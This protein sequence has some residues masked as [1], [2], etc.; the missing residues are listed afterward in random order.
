[1]TSQKTRTISR[2]AMAVTAICS[3]SAH[4][5]NVVILDN[6]STGKLSAVVTN[7]NTGL[8]CTKDQALYQKLCNSFKSN[9]LKVMQKNADG[10]LRV[11][12]GVGNASSTSYQKAGTK[13]QLAYFTNG[14]HLFD[15]DR[16][17]RAADWIGKKATIKIAKGTYGTITW[18]EF[19]TAV[20]AGDTLYGLVRVLVPLELGTTGG[21]NALGQASTKIYGF[22]TSTAAGCGCAPTS[23][24]SDIKPG[25][26][27]CGT[28]FPATAQINVRGALMMDFVDSI[29]NTPVSLSELPFAPRDIYLKVNVP[30]NVNAAYDLNADGAMDNM[31]YISGISDSYTCAAGG[32]DCSLPVTAAV[33]FANIPPESLESYRFK[34]GSALTAAGFNVLPAADKYHLLLPSGYAQG[35]VDA[36]NALGIPADEWAAQGFGVPI[37][38]G[39][40]TADDIRSDKFEDIPAYLYTGGLVDMHY[41]VNI[42][43]LVYVP[44]AM[45]LEQKSAAARQYI[46]G[47]IIVRDS[48]FLET[49]GGI[50]LIG[51][52]PDSYSGALVSAT[53]GVGGQ[54]QRSEPSTLSGPVNATKPGT[55]SNKKGPKFIQVTPTN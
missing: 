22:C 50:T 15:L 48:F 32:T 26:T 23:S 33:A 39:F 2:L 16:F 14:T 27:M 29:T 19:V 49:G 42:S 34:N 6:T 5:A 8:G 46:M 13:D 18:K 52:D 11:D 41:H 9:E 21:T 30:I 43:G 3:W 7:L 53:S 55:A 10:S 12:I 51:G 37:A 35:W 31:D 45:E 17:R 20:A 36:F 44:Q 25:S 38:S 4:G 28:V 1:M 40:M 54:F 47:G 24:S